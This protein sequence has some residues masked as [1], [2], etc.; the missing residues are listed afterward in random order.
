MLRTIVPTLVLLAACEAPGTDPADLSEHVTLDWSAGETFHVAASQRVANV[1]TTNTPSELA[2]GAVEPT[3]EDWWTDPA[4]WTFQAVELGLV[5]DTDDELY[6]Y[7]V[8]ATGEVGAIDVIRAWLDPVANEGSD[9]LDADPVV[10]LVFQASR[11]RLA[12]VV[13]FVDVDGE[14]VETAYDSSDLDHSWGSLSQTML[15]DVPTLLAPFTTRFE[16]AATTLENGDVLTTGLVEGDADIVEATYD[17]VFGGGTIVSRYERGAPWPTHTRTATLDARLLTTGEVDGL[18]RTRSAAWLQDTEAPD[19]FDYRA[20]LRSTVDLDASLVLDDET[21]AGGW[22]EAPYAEFTPWAGSWWPLSQSALV[23]GYDGRDTFS[24]RLF[25]DLKPKQSRRDEIQEELRDLDRTTEEGKT[26]Y[27]AL[28]TEYRTLSDEIVTLLVDFYGG[29]RDDL[30]G[31]TLV[32]ADGKLTHDDGWSYDLDE[33]S[34]FDKFGLAEYLRDANINNPFY[35]SAWEL[36]NQYNPVGGS[37]WGKCNGWAA[38]A[39]L[40]N[41]PVEPVSVTLK[42][43]ELTFTTADQ[44]GLLASSFYGVR[45]SFYGARY[46]GE[47]DDIADLHPDAFHRIVDFYIRRQR[48]PF[49]FDTTAGDAVWNYPVAGATMVV[50]ETTPEGQASLVNLN[51]ATFDE[52]VELPGIG[53]ALAKAILTHRLYVGPFQAVDDLE[54]VRGIGPA[55]LAEVTDL[56]TVEAA[57]RTFDV[58][59][60]I[61]LE[62]DGVSED[63]VSTQGRSTTFDKI[64]GYELTTDAK[65]RVLEGTWD[66]PKEHPDF[67]WVP[68]DNPRTRST[69]GSENPFLEY[70]ALLDVLGEDIERR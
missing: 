64:W 21:M 62:D 30:D 20:A 29:I 51:T 67:A 17:D 46:N 57:E 16:D 11:D 24:D 33:L 18:R 4:V 59:A 19:D 27:D 66:N 69:S 63:W 54:D 37:W 42:G 53:D 70:A 7:A 43:V 58:E 15:T 68:Y 1:K 50:T 48:V 28:V 60:T 55:T 56:V 47:D 6:A 39:I 8:D 41:E 61:T 31:G 13:S 26:T 38:S 10:Y 36:L 12:A 34:P 9:L 3:T 40:A 22:A 49:V 45:S 2:L 5:P 44:K 32:I 65:G 23:F 14:R 35:L 52:L 25:D